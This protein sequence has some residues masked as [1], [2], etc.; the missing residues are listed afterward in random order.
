MSNR[1][2]ERPVSLNPRPVSTEAAPERAYRWLKHAIME[3]PREEERLFTENEVA[4]SAGLS[5]TPVREAIL[6]L[7][8]EGFIRRIP[9][10]GAYVPAIT[11]RDV[12]ATMQAREL[13]EVWSATHPRAWD[14]EFLDALS[15]L[16]D[17]QA[18]EADPVEFITADLEFHTQIVQAAGNLVLADFYRTLRDRQTRMGVR[19]VTRNAERRKRVLTEHRAIVEAM[20]SGDSESAGEAV[21]GHLKSTLDAMIDSDR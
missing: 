21:R 9:Y 19:A 11:D 2:L 6:R 17:R 16:L 12:R 8:A 10:K 20:R 4:D 5:R 14:E 15:D 18:E 7:E 1:A 13:V 3:L